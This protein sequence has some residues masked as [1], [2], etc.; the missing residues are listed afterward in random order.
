MTIDMK[1]K[2]MGTI[3]ENINTILTTKNELANIMIENDVTVPQLFEDY[4]D[5]ISGI[6]GDDNDLIENATYMTSYIMTG[7]NNQ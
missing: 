4:P 5:A 2:K 6:I 7:E 3:I 1:T